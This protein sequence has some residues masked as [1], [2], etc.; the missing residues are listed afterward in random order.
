[1]VRSGRESPVRGTSFADGT[2]LEDYFPDQGRI[3]PKVLN[4]LRRTL[5]LTPMPIFYDG[6]YSDRKLEIKEQETKAEAQEDLARKRAAEGRQAAEVEV[7]EAAA[8][9]E[10]RQKRD[11]SPSDDGQKQQQDCFLCPLDK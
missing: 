11:Q 5:G 9:E 8:L 7:K 10:D 6:T 4:D 3:R 2:R 1:M